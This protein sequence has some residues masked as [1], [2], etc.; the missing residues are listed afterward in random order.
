MKKKKKEVDLSCNG[1]VMATKVYFEIRQKAWKNFFFFSARNLN[2][3]AEFTKNE[4]IRRTG[5][6]K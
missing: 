5:H 3:M 1:V 2:I 6:K 4:R